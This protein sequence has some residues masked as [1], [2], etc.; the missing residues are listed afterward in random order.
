MN[1]KVLMFTV[2][3]TLFF[4][5]DETFKKSQHL[6]TLIFIPSQC[7]A[8]QSNASSLPLIYDFHVVLLLVNVMFPSELCQ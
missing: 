7:T 3:K 4:S 6:F 5:R 2:L 8:M 1:R